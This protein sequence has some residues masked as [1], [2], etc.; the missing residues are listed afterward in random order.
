M[1][2]TQGMSL[3]T[4]PPSRQ[5]PKTSAEVSKAAPPN[6]QGQEGSYPDATVVPSLVKE[7]EHA[8]DWIGKTEKAMR[9]AL[10]SNTSRAWQ[11]VAGV[12]AVVSDM[13]NAMEVLAGLT[14][15]SRNKAQ[16]AL[17]AVQAA[18]DA[19]QTAEEARRVAEQRAEVAQQAVREA[20]EIAIEAKNAETKVERVE[21]I[22]ATARLADTPV[23]WNEAL[24]Q[25]VAA[26]SDDV[27]DSSTHSHD[28]SAL[29]PRSDLWA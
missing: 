12:A 29:T 10:D 23:G 18:Q 26:A 3:E 25:V 4:F 19:A 15:I 5:N 6:G 14:E 7:R 27:R 2:T 22:V 24:K 1:T 17:G 8:V 11:E 9:L 21:Q 28:N 13:A 20:H 16:A